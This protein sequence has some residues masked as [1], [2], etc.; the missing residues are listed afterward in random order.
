M[1]QMHKSRLPESIEI[2]ESL[3]MP[4]LPEKPYLRTLSNCSYYNIIT[5][6]HQSNYHIQLDAHKKSP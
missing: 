5:L 1:T 3:F 6:S 2:L 4:H